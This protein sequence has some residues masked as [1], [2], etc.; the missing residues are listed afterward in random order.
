MELL[1]CKQQKLV[2]TSS[3]VDEKERAMIDIYDKYS[4]R[5][6]PYQH[7]GVPPIEEVNSY[8]DA[9]SIFD[10]IVVMIKDTYKVLF[11]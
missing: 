4:W 8:Q 1:Q 9:E 3:T 6:S 10:E 11:G 5:R 7:D 2:N